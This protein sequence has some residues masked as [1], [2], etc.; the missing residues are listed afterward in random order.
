[1]SGPG[2]STRGTGPTVAARPGHVAILTDQIKPGGKRSHVDALSAG[3]RALGWNVSTL[4]WAQ[5]SFIER[6]AVVLP[7]QALNRFQPALGHRWI[8]P[9]Y[10][11]TLEQRLRQLLR[12]RPDIE[13]LSLH[14]PYAFQ[15]ARRAAPGLP[16]A[17]TVHGPAHRE[18]ASGYGL[19][20]E[21]RTIRWLRTFEERAF[22]EADAVI[23]VDRAHADYVRGFGRADRIWVIPNF[24]DTRRF[25]PGLEPEPFDL[26]TEEWVAGR[27]V[28]L[29]PRLLV[30]KNGVA[31]AIEAAAVL[32]DRRTPF[33]LVIAGDGPQR[34]ALVT[35]VRE[36]NLESHVEF[37]GLAPVER[38]P[39]WCRRA[40]TVIVPS[41]SSKGVE[42][43]TS[44]T[45]IEGQACG[46][47]V[48]ASALGGLRE[49]IESERTGLLVP[50]GDPGALA[51]AIRRVLDDPD[52]ARRLGAAGSRNV[53]D[54][55]SHE[56]GARRFVE[57]FRTIAAG[58]T[59]SASAAR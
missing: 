4:G 2:E 42:E 35:R 53:L 14:E 21:H 33:A 38:M 52:L 36:L 37:A 26:P 20:I 17:L 3:L 10:N 51:D 31:I 9:S 57:V 59:A 40:A 41:V 28:V 23:S 12:R 45:A 54:H 34:P 1:M 32:R 48:V 16:I 30:P 11:Q 46:R 47:P 56:T 15:Y 7:T 29:C 44:I 27:P 22:R 43:A 25:H 18:V 6:A 55:H 24:V 39:G 58:P 8:I 13:V 50:P 5:F 19:P 49:L